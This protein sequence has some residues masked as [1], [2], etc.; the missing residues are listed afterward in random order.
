MLAV[1]TKYISLHPTSRGP[2]L[3]LWEPYTQYIISR[4]WYVLGSIHSALARSTRVPSQWQIPA[5][6]PFSHGDARNMGLGGDEGEE[7]RQA[8]RRPRGGE[9][10]EGEEGRPGG[11]QLES[12]NMR[13][14]TSRYATSNFSMPSSGH[15][16][17]AM[18]DVR[19]TYLPLT[20]YLVE[21]G[22]KGG[23]VCTSRRPR[24]ETDASIDGLHNG[25]QA[26][27]LPLGR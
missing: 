4:V 5:L 22:V 20:S 12:A 3:P 13:A 17:C 2:L 26:E 11:E 10:L 7:A 27:P 15:G 21:L 14:R 18:H 8:S 24:H 25:M 9:Q 23:V 1:R 19:C 16:Q 6:R